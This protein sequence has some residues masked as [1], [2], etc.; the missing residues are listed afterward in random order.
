MVLAADISYAVHEICEK[1]L[2]PNKIS[3]PHTV[4]MHQ[5]TAG[6]YADYINGAGLGHVTGEEVARAV[7][8]A[9]DWDA[10]SPWP[11]HPAPELVVEKLR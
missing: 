6:Y 7:I 3:P 1:T 8:A 4:T 11:G 2:I 9:A 5:A 10:S